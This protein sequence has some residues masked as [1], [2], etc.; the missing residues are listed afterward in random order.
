[1]VW[2]DFSPWK[3]DVILILAILVI[4]LLLSFKSKTSVREVP[5]TK[6]FLKLSYLNRKCEDYA[7]G[8]KIESRLTSNLLIRQSE[9]GWY[10]D[11]NGEKS[12]ELLQDKEMFLFY[13]KKY[14][15][16]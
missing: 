14:I 6:R 8:L 1:M 11:E 7:D 5:E 9:T 12:K 3:S 15:L 16:V 10:D 2:K 4:E 13:V